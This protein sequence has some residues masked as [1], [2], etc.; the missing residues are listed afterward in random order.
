MTYNSDL[1]IKVHKI[2][3]RN[4]KLGSAVMMGK[5]K[6]CLRWRGIELDGQGFCSFKACQKIKSE[7]DR[8]QVRRLIV[9]TLEERR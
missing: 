2:C 1:I 9:K 8:E 6:H 7:I 5:C 3:D 4:D